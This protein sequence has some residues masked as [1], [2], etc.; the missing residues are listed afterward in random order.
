MQ[1]ASTLFV[2]KFFPQENSFIIRGGFMQK[3][4]V[5]RGFPAVVDGQTDK[6]IV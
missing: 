3:S 6:P 4:Q 1:I 2:F 5:K